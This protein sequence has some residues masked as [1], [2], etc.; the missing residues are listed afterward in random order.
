VHLLKG[1]FHLPDVE[2]MLTE[3]EA[4]K[5]WK[6]SFMPAISSRATVIKLHMVHFHDELLRDMAINP[7][8]KKNLFLEWFSDYRPADHREVL[9]E[10]A[11]S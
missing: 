2:Q 10:I 11:D 3:I 1:K 5:R 8:R 9:S 6:H 4:I 7:Y